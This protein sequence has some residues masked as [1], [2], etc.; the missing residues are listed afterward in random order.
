MINPLNPDINEA[1]FDGEVDRTRLIS[2]AETA[3]HTVER[4][5]HIRDVDPTADRLRCLDLAHVYWRDISVQRFDPDRRVTVEDVLTV[6]DQYVLWLR[7]EV[8]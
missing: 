4:V 3:S 6:A 5:T 7:G 1:T 8:R 2:I